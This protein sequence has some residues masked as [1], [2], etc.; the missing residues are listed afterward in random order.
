[1][2]TQYSWSKAVGRAMMM[3]R[4]QLSCIYREGGG[5]EGGRVREKHRGR[6]VLANRKIDKQ[7]DRQT[8]QTG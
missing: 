7:T 3:I 4:E 6:E 2:F 5:R 8:V 1:M